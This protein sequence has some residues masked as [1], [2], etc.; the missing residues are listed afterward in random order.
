[1]TNKNKYIL[2]LI[3]CLIISAC[4]YNSSDN[5]TFSDT[6]SLNKN[7]F[8]QTDTAKIKINTAFPFGC[9]DLAKYNYPHYWEEDHEHYGKLKSPEGKELADIST[10]LSSINNAKTIKAPIIKSIEYLDLNKEYEGDA[11]YFDT[12]AVRKMDSCIYRLPD[13]SKYQCYYYRQHSSKKTYGIYGSLLLLDPATQIGK[14]L[15]LYFE[16]GGDQHVKLRYYFIDKDTIH[17]YDG[18]CYDDGTTLAEAFKITVNEE[19]EIVLIK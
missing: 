13:I 1:M 19:G 11:Y 8:I 10:L 6:T 14:L 4:S 16:C 2:I 17:I 5:S 9:A 12:I 7:E 15:T 3:T 18:A